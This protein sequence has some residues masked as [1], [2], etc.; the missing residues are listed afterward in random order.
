MFAALMP[1]KQRAV[2]ARRLLEK[3][4]GWGEETFWTPEMVRV[5]AALGEAEASRRFAR[6]GT[7]IRFAM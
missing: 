2:A 4:K 7:I 5:V 1:D 3:S 6:S